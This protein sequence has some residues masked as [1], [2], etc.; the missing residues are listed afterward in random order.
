MTVDMFLKL[1]DIKGE[2]H[3]EKHKD[4]IDVLAWSWGMSNG[5][6]L[7]SGGGGGSGKVNMQDISITKHV[8]SSSNALMMD[9]ATGRHVKVASLTVR[10]AGGKA[11]EYIKLKFE[12]VLISSVHT[13]GSHGETALTEN[14]T[15]AFAKVSFEYTPQKEDGSGGAGMKF[16]YDIKRNV[17]L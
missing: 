11:L 14:V 17:K 6:S 12:D 15:L 13:G 4:S 8:D 1:D 5:A 7:G 9:C 3:D 2:S 16:G 10:K